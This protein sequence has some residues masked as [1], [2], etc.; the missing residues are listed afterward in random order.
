LKRK[1]VGVA[2]GL[3]GQ[4]SALPGQSGTAP[5]WCGVVIPD[6]TDGL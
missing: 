3:A 1:P 4:H 2:A 5:V 6:P